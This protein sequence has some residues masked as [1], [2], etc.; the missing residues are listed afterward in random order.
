[1]SNFSKKN[2]FL[3]ALDNGDNPENIICTSF[4][5]ILFWEV[6][7]KLKH[8][9]VLLDH[10]LQLYYRRVPRIIYNLKRTLRNILIFF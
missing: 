7:L 1:V 4:S 8:K 6:S 9:F 10:V 5:G 3:E 2:S